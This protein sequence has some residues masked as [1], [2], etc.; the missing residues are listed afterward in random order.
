MF[1]SSGFTHAQH[2]FIVRAA[3][4]SLDGFMPFYDTD[5][6]DIPLLISFDPTVALAEHHF[7]YAIQQKS[8]LDQQLDIYGDTILL[9]GHNFDYQIPINDTFI[10]SGNYRLVFRLIQPSKNALVEE[11]EILIQTLRKPNTYYRANKRSPSLLVSNK[12]IHS[13]SNIDVSKTFVA[14]YDNV[15]FIKRNIYALGPIAEKAEEGALESISKNDN[16][17]EL[18]RFFYNFWYARNPNNPEAAWQLYVEK[19]NFVAKKYAFGALKG[20]QTDMG[21]LYLK[22]GPPDQE[23]KASNE[24]GTRPYEI[25]FYRELDK[26]TNLNILFAQITSQPNERVILHSTSPDFFFNPGWESQ[27][28]TDPSEINNRNSHRVYDFFK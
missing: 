5:E 10:K 28:F 6:N 19:L 21:I 24:R 17:E 3:K 15:D 9:A 26:F 11:K 20:Y 8:T 13:V 16:L 22:Y 1:L 4:D 14:R 7:T 25:W 2:S 18:Q 23:V 27:L 12:V